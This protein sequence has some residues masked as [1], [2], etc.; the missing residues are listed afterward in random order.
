MKFLT[1]LL[2][3]GTCFSQGDFYIKVDEPPI[4]PGCEMIINQQDRI[5][6]SKMQ[7]TNFIESSEMKCEGSFIV[8]FLV[9]KNGN[10]D[11]V[12][13][14][15]VRNV[16]CDTEVISKI[17]E[18]FNRSGIKWIPGKYNQVEVDVQMT[19]NLNFIKKKNK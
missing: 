9:T 2:I 3:T 5:E 19:T 7:F 10:V 13:L 17:F 14:K 1:L 8:N 6:C 16:N 4:F 18:N 12:E 11:K 15:E